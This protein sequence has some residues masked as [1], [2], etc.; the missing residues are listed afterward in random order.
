[1]SEQRE[2]YIMKNLSKIQEAALQRMYDRAIERGL[3]NP[4]NSQTGVLY[5]YGDCV[6]VAL[7]KEL[8]EFANAAAG[9]SNGIRVGSHNSVSKVKE[10]FRSFESLKNFV[11]Q[12]EC[13]A[14]DGERERVRQR[15][16]NLIENKPADA[17]F[18]YLHQK[19][20]IRALAEK[21][22][23]EAVVTARQT[24]TVGEFELRFGLGS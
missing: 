7:P 10:I 3:K 2:T 20:D 14:L 4:H 1:M 13:N 23:K 19:Y 5:A 12:S 6:Q 22:G 17:N 24:L 15:V 9:V 11:L 18:K 16:R 8:K 21:F